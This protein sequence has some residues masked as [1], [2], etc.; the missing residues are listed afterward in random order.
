MSE[1]R[2]Q[3][4]DITEL[5]LDQITEEDLMRARFRMLEP[6]PELRRAMAF[7]DDL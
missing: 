4:D 5:P 2:Q 3:L 7:A 6:D 1:V